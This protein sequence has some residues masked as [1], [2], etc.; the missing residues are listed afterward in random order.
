LIFRGSEKSRQRLWVSF[1]RGYRFEVSIYRDL[2]VSGVEFVAHDILN[3]DERH[4]PFDL[5]VLGLRGDIKY[6]TYFLSAD[7]LSRAASDF[8]ITRIYDVMERE[9]LY[10]VIIRATVWQRFD[11][12]TVLTSRSELTRLLPSPSLVEIN[13]NMIVVISYKDW[14]QRVRERQSVDKEW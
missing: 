5:I 8:F 9:W 12:M 4:S 13:G 7:M 11:G 14:K 3:P 2:K 6:S 10:I 1:A